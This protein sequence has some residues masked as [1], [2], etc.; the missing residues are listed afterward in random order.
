VIFVG[1]G[2]FIQNYKPNAV[3]SFLAEKPQ[4]P[5][6]VHGFNVFKAFPREVMLQG[7]GHLMFQKGMPLSNPMP[8]VGHPTE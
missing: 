5:W 8:A 4:Q 3:L 2:Q 6:R 7:D 1:D